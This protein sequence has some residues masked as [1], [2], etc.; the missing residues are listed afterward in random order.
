M[1]GFFKTI[2]G[3]AKEINTLGDM[4]SNYTLKIE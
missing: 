2:W 1:G 3:N 4:P